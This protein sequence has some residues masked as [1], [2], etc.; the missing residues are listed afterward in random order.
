LFESKE[1]YNGEGD[2]YDGDAEV[3][4]KGDKQNSQ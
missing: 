4:S 2:E 1:G 3:Q